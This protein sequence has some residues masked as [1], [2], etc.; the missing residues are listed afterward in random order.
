MGLSCRAGPTKRPGFPAVNDMT[1]GFHGHG[2]THNGWS[3]TE[4]PHRSKWM[5]TRGTPETPCKIADL[6]ILAKQSTRAFTNSQE[7][8]LLPCARNI[9]C[10]CTVVAYSLSSLDIELSK[11]RTK[12]VNRKHYSAMTGKIAIK[13]K[14]HSATPGKS[15]A[16]S[17][18]KLCP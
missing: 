7:R 6:R 3:K 9:K 5:M 10:I 12:H 13:N 2:G 16:T 18:Q 14:H 15:P 4:N 1:G 11:F 17:S 8:I